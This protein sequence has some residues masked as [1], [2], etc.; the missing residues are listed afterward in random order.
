MRFYRTLLHL[1]PASF[2]AEYG[3]EMCAM[4]NDRLRSTFGLL[5][6]LALWTE[7]VVEILFNALGV[8]GDLLRQDLHYT[9]RTLSR[10]PGFAIIVILVA[11]LGVGA[12]TAV[13]TITDHVLLRP[14]PFAESHRLVKLWENKPGYSQMELSPPNYR[15][16][17]ARSTSF[18]TMAAY[19]GLSVNLSGQGE[20]EMLDGSCVTADLFPMLGVQPAL[21]R[22]FSAEDDRPDTPAT[23]ILSY[24]LWQ[25]AFGGDAGVIGRKVQ[26]NGLPWTVI[27]VMPRG[28]HF[29]SRDIEIWAPMRFVPQ[30]FEDRTNNYLPV[31]ARLKPGVSLTQ[32]RE[33][34]RLIT[35]QLE[36]E[37]PKENAKTGANVNLLRD[38][39]SRQSRLLLGA[40]FG[41]ALCVLLIACTNLANLLLARALARRKE[42]AVRSSLGA[43]RER[44]VRQLMTE[45]SVL[46]VLGGALGIFAAYA[47]LPLL[48]RLVPQSLPIPEPSIDLR[49]LLSALAFTFVTGLGF[50]VIPALRAASSGKLH[51]GAR[52]GIGSRKERLRSALVIVEVT[53]SVVLL[54]SAG[55][56]IR[57]LSRLQAT[58]P[59]F[60]AEGVLT[61]RTSLPM[62]A[63]EAT[64]RRT[65]FYSRVLTEVRALPGVN[66]AAYISFLPM[67]LRGGIWPVSIDGIQRD[68]SAA[69]TASLRYVTP[70]FFSTLGVPLRSGRDVADSDITTAPNV[71]VVSESFVRQIGRAH[72]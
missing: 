36:R 70:G 53:V 31:I 32:A 72:V 9:A 40:L 44:L 63:Y 18:E 5:G 64:A 58:D 71:A 30:D 20:P 34:M 14:L 59:G 1:Y 47:A 26:L 4:F 11:A 21:G 24:G 8:H 62:P 35:A 51:E 23:V 6:T 25:A 33:E 43:G 41:A 16:W 42:I 27:G 48:N 19:R 54:V 57:A 56:L 68:R 29:P 10:S 15:D 60:R 69:H 49:M 52:G 7:T 55:L 17:K 2:R 46:A 50:G 67:T 22:L 45:S 65:Q 28:F 37:Y 12:T 61:L 38:E 3:E 66:S 39:V 13:F